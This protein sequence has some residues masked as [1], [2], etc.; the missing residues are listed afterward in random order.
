MRTLTR[1][2]S[3]STYDFVGADVEV[4]GPGVVVTPPSHTQ[5]PFSSRRNLGRQTQMDKFAAVWL[6]IS[7]RL[8]PVVIESKSHGR[9]T[10]EGFFEAEGVVVVV[11]VL[12][13]VVVEV[14]EGE[15]PPPPPPQGSGTGLPSR[16]LGKGRC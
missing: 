2:L 1:V 10:G 5:I 16:Q 8:H 4:I 14:G 3:L 7:V 13:V 6:H 15:S 12:E 11:V 9:P